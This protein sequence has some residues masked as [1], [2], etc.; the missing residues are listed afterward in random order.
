MFP[1]FFN[2]RMRMYTGFVLAECSCIAVGLGAYPVKSE[3]KPGQGPKNLA[4]LEEM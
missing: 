4:A 3:P 1:V 2:F